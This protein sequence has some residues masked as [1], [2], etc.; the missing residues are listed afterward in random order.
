MEDKGVPTPGRVAG[1]E[2]DIFEAVSD[3][4]PIDLLPASNGP[5][6]D[7]P[8]L[9]RLNDIYKTESEKE[10]LRIIVNHLVKQKLLYP[11]CSG[12]LGHGVAS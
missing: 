3:C 7:S 12:D 6:P 2:L 5:S 8:A 11:T 9:K 10:Q 1:M 4:G